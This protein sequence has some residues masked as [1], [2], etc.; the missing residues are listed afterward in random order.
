MTA[1]RVLLY[2]PDEAE[3]YARLVK[4]PKG[5]IRLEVCSTPEEVVGRIPEAE[6]LYAWHF[7]YHLLAQA[8]SLRWIQAMGAGVERFLVPDLLPRVV[9]TRA[10]GM[11]GAW[12]AEYTLGWCAWVTQ[13]MELLREAQRQHH[14]HPFIPEPLHDRTL[15]IVGLGDIGRVIARAAAALGMRVIGVSRSGR[16]QRGVAAVY[17]PSTLPRVLG[18]ADF[19]VLVLPLTDETHGLIGEKELRAMKRTAWLLNVGRGAVI[20]E[21]ALIHALSEGWIAGT[22]LDVFDTEPLRRDHP[23]WDMPNVIITPHIAGPSIP[24]EIAPV[25]N[26]NLRR[27]LRGRKLLYAVD[28]TRAY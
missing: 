24:A 4:A 13:R 6:I 26:E 9:V 3:S 16:Q 19:A 8:K 7:P 5:A 17:R 27:Y 10:T 21:P 11:F 25:F 15:L 18:Q 14:W 22:I 23:L 28:R 12:M 2:D 20:N 1:R